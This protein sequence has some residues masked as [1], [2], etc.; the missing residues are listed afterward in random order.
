M[1]PFVYYQEGL[2]ELALTAA[3]YCLDPENNLEELLGESMENYN[4]KYY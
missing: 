4:K 1:D 2:E 3:T